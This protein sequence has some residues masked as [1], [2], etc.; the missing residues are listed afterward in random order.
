MEILKSFWILF[1]IGMFSKILIKSWECF[2]S[3]Y[4]TKNTNMRIQIQ[5]DYIVT[6]VNLHDFSNIQNFQEF[7]TSNI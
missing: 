5:M 2:K 4:L 7:L 1:E 6:I 3:P